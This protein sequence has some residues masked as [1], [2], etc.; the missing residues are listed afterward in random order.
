M[1]VDVVPN[2]EYRSAPAFEQLAQ[3]TNDIWGADVPV[4]Q[5][6]GVERYASSFWFNAER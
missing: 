6:P 5:E 1:L 2:N 4:A 3:E